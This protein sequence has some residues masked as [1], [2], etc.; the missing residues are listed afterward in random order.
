MQARS[1]AQ[2]QESL[3]DGAAEDA[4]LADLRACVYRAARFYLQRHADSLAHRSP[5]EIAA[6]ADDAAQDAVM[7]ILG[8]LDN[9]RGEAAFTT[10]AAKFG[11]TA[12]AQIL[13]R[14]QWR[15]VSLEDMPDGWDTTLAGLVARNDGAQPELAAQRREVR[16][17]LLAVVREDLTD[18]QRQV[19]GY[20][21]FQGVP[22][23]EGAERLGIS[24]GACYKLAHDARRTFRR[25]VERRGWTVAEV[26][27][28]FAGTA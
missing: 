25:G 3:R 23:D 21:L 20:V 19:F 14:R 28:A 12:A 11:V 6:M 27:A 8:K 17:L 22:P 26:L 1:N 2:W 10:W 15:D 18:K 16:T 24:R 13:R 4:A 9:Y 7:G 5:E